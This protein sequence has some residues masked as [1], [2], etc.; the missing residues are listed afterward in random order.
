MTTVARKVIALP[1]GTESKSQ[2]L[3]GF[4]VIVSGLAAAYYL[5]KQARH[6]PQ[7]NCRNTT[8]DQDP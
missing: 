7:S 3:A 2:L 5:M 4:D 1:A 6:D 8:M